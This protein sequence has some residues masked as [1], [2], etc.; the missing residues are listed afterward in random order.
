[1]NTCYSLW[2]PEIS[3]TCVWKLVK[4]YQYILVKFQIIQIGSIW[5]L[6][7]DYFSN[8]TKLFA[9]EIIRCAAETNTFLFMF[10][11]F[12]HWISENLNQSEIFEPENVIINSE[13]NAISSYKSNSLLNENKIVLNEGERE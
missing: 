1:M 5:L 8:A 12:T 7:N 9:V 6:S 2:L 10:H 11:I 3:S 13:K 4:L